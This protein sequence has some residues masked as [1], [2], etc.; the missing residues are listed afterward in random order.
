MAFGVDEMGGRVIGLLEEIRQQI[1][2]K[3]FRFRR[4]E[5]IQQRNQRG[6]EPLDLGSGRLHFQ[7]RLIQRLL[8]RELFHDSCAT[9]SYSTMNNAVRHLEGV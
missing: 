6:F 4:I 7:K 8:R 2:M 1:L 5:M 9:S 3:F